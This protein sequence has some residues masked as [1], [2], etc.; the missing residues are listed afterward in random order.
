MELL[1]P[2]GSMECLVAAVQNGAD[3]VYFGGGSFNARRYA[4]NFVGDRLIR[5]IDYCHER[6]TRAYITLNTLVFDREI[7]AALDFASELYSLGADAVLVQDIGLASAIRHS[8]PNLTLHASTQ[9]GIHDLGGL[10]YCHDCGFTRA[11]LARETR[12]EWIKY[13]VKHSKIEIE[14]FAHGALCMSFSGSCLY[15]SMSG[16]RSGNRGTCAQPCRKRASTSGR[17][18]EDDFCLSPSDICMLEH[19]SAL[20]D[21]GVACVKIE[22]RMKKPEYVAIVTRA[23][24]AALDGASDKEIRKLKSELFE[25][26]N[27]GSFNTAHLFSDSVRTDRV[28][29]SKPSKELVALAQ[30]SM[31]GENRKREVDMRLV[32]KVGENASLSAKSEGHEVECNGAVVQRA[33]R[34]QTAEVY[35]E[36]LKKL[37]D[38]PFSLGRCSVS[39]AKDCYI[40]AA[41][42]NAMRRDAVSKLLN[43]FHVRNAVPKIEVS[44]RNV[45]PLNKNNTIAEPIVYARAAS[46]KSARIAFDNGADYVAIE[47][48][49][50]EI[51]QFADLQHYRDEGKKLIV[52]LPNVIINETQQASVRKLLESGLLDGAEANNIGQTEMIKNLPIRIAGIG[53]N[54][55]N[56]HTV[57][58]LIRLGYNFVIPSPELTGVQLAALAEKCSERLLIWLH[59]RVPLMQLLHCPVK[60]HGGCLDC[61]GEAGRVTDEAGREFPLINTKFSDKCLVRML[62][63]RTTDLIDIYDE[64]P[65]AAGAVLSFS[66]EA[67]DMM[68]DR[69]SAFT[70]ARSGRSVPQ[71]PNSTRG[72]FNRKVE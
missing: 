8:L 60:E 67:E 50:F 40:S 57:N 17:P 16:E 26:F 2:A 58:E 64:L 47:P 33:N 44:D 55:M 70:A 21:A 39:M 1:S 66:G 41:E 23:Y 38:T 53:M 27:R 14:T 36:R 34:P 42:L 4:D 31:A 19:L 43:E 30:S 45:V 51:N 12:L 25:L 71:L 62:N 20:R 68:I 52:A 13:L 32:L 3:A 6:D 29:S 28:G 5:A 48:I 9:M 59:G 72:H 35:V 15:S 61:N 56:S 11:V 18:G 63:C 24:R 54:A 46:A 37:G 22:G 7:P 10:E 69:L 49:K 65:R